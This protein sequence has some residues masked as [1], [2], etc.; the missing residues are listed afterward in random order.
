M[1]SECSD[2]TDDYSQKYG[3]AWDVIMVAMVDMNDGTSWKGTADHSKWV[4]STSSGWT[5]AADINRMCSQE[6]RGGGALCTNDANIWSAYTKI[7]AA[8]EECWAQNPCTGTSTQCY[9]C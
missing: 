1:G 4:A 5:C 7:I 8:T 3:R 9:W 2:G 6:N